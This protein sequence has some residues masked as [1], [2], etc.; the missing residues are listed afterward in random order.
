MKPLPKFIVVIHVRNEKQ[1]VIDSITAL[2]NGA[3]GIFL[4]N[5]MSDYNHLLQCYN[6][7]REVL[8]YDSAFIGLNFL[9]L[10][11]EEA[12]N[13]LPQDADALWC[14]NVYINTTD[15]DV[16]K[17]LD[18]ME[19]CIKAGE[20]QSWRMF[21]SFAFKYQKPEPNVKLAAELTASVYSVAVT[22][23]NATGKSADVEKIRQCMFGSM[24]REGKL[25]IAS[26]I[27]HENIC[28]Y[29]EYVNCFMVATGVSD[30]NDNL[31]PEKIKTLS[32][33]INEPFY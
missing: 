24:S 10:K 16:T 2:A 33:M 15:T 27:T 21:A 17:R 5:H 28:N 13:I 9:D 18:L 20:G 25:A 1:T 4:I 22:S 30:E 31:V 23:G 8:P 6:S 12:V 11:A 14:D 26:G 29:L 32:R 7:V 3:G 19:R